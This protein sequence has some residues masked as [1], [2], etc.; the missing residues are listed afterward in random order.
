MLEK[1][2]TVLYYD[3]NV[4]SEATTTTPFAHMDKQLYTRMSSKLIGPGG[5]I[6]ISQT[7]RNICFTSTFTAKEGSTSLGV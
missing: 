6:D 7:T 2:N 3:F 1:G 4:A 5:F